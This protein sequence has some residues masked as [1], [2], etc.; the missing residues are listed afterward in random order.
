MPLL[1]NRASVVET[2]LGITF[3]I[4]QLPTQTIGNVTVTTRIPT[5]Y[6]ITLTAANL[7]GDQA[8]SVSP[9]PA[10]L[11]AGTQLTF[12]TT[13]ATLSNAAPA[14]ST[15][16]QTLPLPAAIASG[17]TATT[18]ALLFVNGCSNAVVSPQIKNTDTTDYLSGLGKESVTTGNAKTMSLD[19]NLIYGDRGGELLKSIAYDPNYA[20]LEFYFYLLYPSGESHAGAA[21]LETATPQNQVQDKRSFQC[22]AQVQGTS[23]VYTPAPTINIF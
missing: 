7:Q 12:G 16:L 15:T 14:G 3:Q 13:V 21:L 23:Y 20:G 19:F 5:S 9:T 1:I 4:G 8:L 10:L 11:D 6:T 22:T 2:T 17:S 18:L